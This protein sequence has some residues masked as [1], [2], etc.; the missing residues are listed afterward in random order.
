VP[1]RL[2]ETDQCFRGAIWC[3]IPEECHLADRWLER[4]SLPIMCSSYTLCAKN[5]KNGMKNV[6][7]PLSFTAVNTSDS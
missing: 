2:V 5:T 1:C 6:T 7:H 4:L 3:N